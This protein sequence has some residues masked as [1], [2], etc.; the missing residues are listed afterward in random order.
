MLIILGEGV[1]NWSTYPILY[2]KRTNRDKLVTIEFIVGEGRSV[3]SEMYDFLKFSTHIQ[4][5]SES[6]MEPPQFF[7]LFIC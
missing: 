3:K 5:C 4:H 1:N 7:L 6:Q 2:L